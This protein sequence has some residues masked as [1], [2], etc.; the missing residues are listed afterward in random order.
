MQFAGSFYD[1]NAIY[2][3]ATNGNGATAWNKLWHSGNDG[4]GSGLDADTLDGTQ[5]G[6]LSVNYANSAGSATS[7]TTATN[8]NGGTISAT[9]SSL[10]TLTHGQNMVIK[11][12]AGNNGAGTG[13]AGLYLWISEPA[14]SWT[15]AGIGRNIY[16]NGASFS[17]VNPALSGQMIRFGEGSDIYFTVE[18]AAGTRYT[19]LSISGDEV[20]TH[21]LKAGNV[22]PGGSTT[23]YWGWDGSGITKYGTGYTYISQG[24]LYVASTIIARGG[25]TNDQQTYI[26]MSSK[27]LQN[28]ATPSNTNDAATKG[29]VDGLI[30]GPY[31]AVVTASANCGTTATATCPAGMRVY[32]EYKCETSCPLDPADCPGVNQLGMVGDAG[33]DQGA[34]SASQVSRTCGSCSRAYVTVLCTKV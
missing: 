1:G 9:G 2:Y 16:N 23:D 29:Y 27:R 13:D 22:Y 21:T 33:A 4:S 5:P 28:V 10:F 15:G 19:P 30:A 12:P 11:L 32:G 8:L 25:I 26:D 6:S 20:T 3:R 34:T 18:S 31:V 24:T 7:A 17:R 14:V